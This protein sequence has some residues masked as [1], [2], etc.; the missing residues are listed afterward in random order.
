VEGSWACSGGGISPYS[1]GSSP[2]PCADILEVYFGTY[3][4]ITLGIQ[5]VNPKY[6]GIQGGAVGRGGSMADWTHPCERGVTVILCKSLASHTV[7]WSHK[8]S[9]DIGQL[10]P[11][12]LR[13]C[14]GVIEAQSCTHGLATDG[15]SNW[16]VLAAQTVVCVTSTPFPGT[17]DI[18][19]ASHRVSETPTSLGAMGVQLSKRAVPAVYV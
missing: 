15:P 2:P 16:T 10:H 14:V 5:G 19:S 4:G 11:E 12:Q 8:P 3:S 17:K 7:F 18:S 1:S 9:R 13:V 6:R